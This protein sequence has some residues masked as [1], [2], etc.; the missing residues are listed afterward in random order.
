MIDHQRLR[1]YYLLEIA[2]RLRGPD[3]DSVIAR[4]KALIGK[5]EAAGNVRRQYIDGWKCIL[6]GGAD[7]LELLAHS[8]TPEALEMQHCMPFA[9]ILSNRDRLELRRKS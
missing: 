1:Q 7:Q 6:D 5:W 4:A 8:T 2:R 9:G 3:R